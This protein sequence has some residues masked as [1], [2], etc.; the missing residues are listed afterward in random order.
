MKAKAQSESNPTPQP[1]VQPEPEPEPTINGIHYRIH[2]NAVTVYQ[3]EG[4]AETFV[5][6]SE[7]ENRPVTKVAKSTF[8]GC[9]SLVHI[10]IPDS[11]IS[12]GES[13]FAE[14]QNL[15]TVKLSK[16]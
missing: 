5:V 8:D 1:V 7:I 16:A 4:N 6:P 11:V 10:E 13:A 12:I 15:E 9:N 14:C 3:Y 2:D